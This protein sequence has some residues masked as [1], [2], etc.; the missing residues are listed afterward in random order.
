VRRFIDPVRMRFAASSTMSTILGVPNLQLIKEEATVSAVYREQEAEQ[1]LADLAWDLLSWIE[2]MKNF[3][4]ASTLPKVSSNRFRQLV[5]NLQRM[6]T[7]HGQR[8]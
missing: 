5:V 1:N 4:T 6:A 3:V 2:T 8:S 7:G